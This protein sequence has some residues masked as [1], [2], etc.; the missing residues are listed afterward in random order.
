MSFVTST[1]MGSITQFRRDDMPS[2][3]TG[4]DDSET[5]M[6]SV[7]SGMPSISSSSELISTPSVTVPA[8]DHNPYIYRESRLT[9]TVFIAVGSVVGAIILAFVLFH[10]IRSIRASML[11]KKSSSGEKSM[12][13][14][15]NRNRLYSN[16]VGL[17]STNFLNTEYQGSVAKIPLMSSKSLYDGSQAGDTSTLHMGETPYATSHH[18]LTN[19]FIS[20]T[21]EVMSHSR[22]K[23]QSNILAGSSMSLRNEPSPAINRHSQ[24]IPNMYLSPAVN[25]SEYSL[26]EHAAGLSGKSSS[27]SPENSPRGR[28]KKKTVPSMYLDDLIDK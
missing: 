17:S 20:P 15:Y 21:K 26:L 27:N 3:T 2:A 10:L 13:E 28:Q 24:L 1:I 5:G 7:D 19:M 6:P 23:S 8:H 11:A 16:S 12:Y 9:G 4:D 22:T 14:N 25:N 18:D